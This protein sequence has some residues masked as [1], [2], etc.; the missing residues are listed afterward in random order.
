VEGEC[1]G[2]DVLS[3]VE[4]EAI[5]VKVVRYPADWDAEGRR[6]GVLRNV[7]MLEEN[8][9][10][11]VIAFSDDIENSKGTRHMCSI[12]KKA[13]VPVYVVSRFKDTST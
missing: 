1:R 5:G 8:H 2:A 9:P 13:G 7:R 3:R 4:A 11:I 12:A 10:D 6:A